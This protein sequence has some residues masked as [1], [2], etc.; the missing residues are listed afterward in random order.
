MA[1]SFRRLAYALGAEVIGADMSRP[2]DGETFAQI[3]QGFL[4]H[5]VLL[6]R[7]QEISRERHIEFSKRFGPLDENKHHDPSKRVPGHSEFFLV[8]NR[9]R[10]GGGAATGPRT[11]EEWHTDYSHLVA[12]ATA[13]L[14]RAME[15]PEVGGDTMFA[16]MYL[17]Y[18]NLSDGMK[19]L[20]DGLYGLHFQG[21]AFKDPSL[22]GDEMRKRFPCAAHPL[23][24]T[25]PET[26]RKA[27]Y[28]NR[29]VKWITGLSAAETRPLVDYLTD[30]ATRT[31]FVY[32]HRWQKHDLIMWDNRCLMHIALGDYDRRELRHME[33]TTVLGGVSG[34]SYD[35]PLD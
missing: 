28:V 14:L 18:D 20:I 10:P 35:G 29:Q 16:N 22:S 15:L 21:A 6:F 8:I 33:R 12:P 4:R 26:G 27:L 30:H 1:I 5:H 34:R 25:H 3:H 32:R 24:K 31:Q 13:S 9:P 19:K 2:L 17:A 7:G 11:G 23:V